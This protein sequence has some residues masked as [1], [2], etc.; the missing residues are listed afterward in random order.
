MKKFL[1]MVLIIV[2][3]GIG[4]VLASCNQ[5]V[6]EQP[7]IE[8]SRS[9]FLENA[10][11]RDQMEKLLFVALYDDGT[12]SLGTPPISSYAI[13]HPLY[14]TLTD[15]ELQIF[16]SAEEPVAHFEVADDNTLIFVKSSVLLYASVGARY[17]YTPQWMSFDGG[18]I[19]VY[20]DKIPGID[21]IKV[22][23]DDVARW[24]V[25]DKNEIVGFADWAGNLALESITFAEGQEPGTYNG[26]IGYLL[27]TSFRAHMFEYG[28]Y[29]DGIH[30]VYIN[31]NWYHVRNPSE[32]PH[33]FASR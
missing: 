14:Y 22:I 18:K 12:A 31:S 24:S 28:I 10:T 16:Y 23:G 21:V 9:Y 19:T 13:V 29:N 30:Y 4:G 20:S 33:V 27:R 25:T 7:Y 1:M 11:Q 17:V 3:M 26:D 6:N 32:L 15:T 5:S 8:A 2:A